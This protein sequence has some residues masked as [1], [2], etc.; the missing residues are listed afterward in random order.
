MNC[1]GLYH[2]FRG[3]I[4][5]ARLRDNTMNTRYNTMNFLV[6]YHRNFRGIILQCFVDNTMFLLCCYVCYV[7]VEKKMFEILVSEY[8]E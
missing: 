4:P 1:T 8:S 6:L 2:A 3:N 7:F 5:Q